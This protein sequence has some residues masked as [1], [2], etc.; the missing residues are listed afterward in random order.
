MH[1]HVV[2]NPITLAPTAQLAM[3]VGHAYPTLFSRDIKIDP[4]IKL[5]LCLIRNNAI[6]DCPE[7]GAICQWI[8]TFQDNRFF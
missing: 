7:G 1:G 5:H 4:L 8:N 6:D 3:A 2:A